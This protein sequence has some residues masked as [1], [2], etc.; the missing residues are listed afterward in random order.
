MSYAQKKFSNERGTTLI[1]VLVAVVVLSVGLLGLA[2]LQGISLRSSANAYNRTQA[3][4][5]SYEI[6][7]QLRANRLEIVRRG[8]PTAAQL[9]VWQN[10]VAA[11]LPDGILEITQPGGAALACNNVNCEVAVRI[12]WADTVQRG[13]S[14]ADSTAAGY[15]STDVDLRWFEMDTRI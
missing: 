7:D 14:A 4:N 9:A 8:G 12:R 5:I 10:Q 15:D 3:T 13:T 2:G 1:E 11:S 6:L